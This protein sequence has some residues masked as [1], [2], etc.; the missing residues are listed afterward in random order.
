MVTGGSAGIGLE[1][2]R[3]LASAGA[4][5]IVPARDVE[6]ARAAVGTLATVEAMELTDPLSIVIGNKVVEGATSEELRFLLGRSFKVTR[7][8]GKPIEGTGLADYV[9][10]TVHPSAIL[11]APDE[12]ARR[13]GRDD[14]VAD[15]EVVR[16]L[17]DG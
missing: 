12:A 3:V 9:V 2:T 13:R 1:T 17:L 15:L 4:R 7:Q 6:K 11:R 14:L 10:A 5:V 16:G 8:R